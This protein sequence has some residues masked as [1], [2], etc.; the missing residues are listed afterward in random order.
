M[1]FGPAHSASPRPPLRRLL[2]AVRPDRLAVYFA[3]RTPCAPDRGQR[4]EVIR[5]DGS[6]PPLPLSG[7]LVPEH[8]DSGT[9]GVRRDAGGAQL[10]RVP[11]GGVV[12]LFL[13]DRGAIQAEALN[14]QG[15]AILPEPGPPRRIVQEATQ[16]L[17]Q[18]Y[19]A[20]CPAI[21]VG[22]DAEPALP[23]KRWRRVGSEQLPESQLA[24]DHERL[25]E[26][27]ST[28]RGTAHAEN[29]VGCGV[30]AT[31]ILHLPPPTNN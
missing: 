6:P 31:C 4:V 19:R 5:R 9:Q 10:A 3:F 12:H 2:R 7:D 1:R 21:C 16:D 17:L 15:P 29:H 24:L 18:P 27:E 11:Q 25:A 22:A 28:Y 13:C 23:K 26:R 8:T 14:H 20:R 30:A